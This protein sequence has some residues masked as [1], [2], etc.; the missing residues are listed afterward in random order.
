M[1]LFDDIKCKYPLPVAGA[2]KLD[3]QTK[4]TPSQFMDQYEIREDG[5]LWYEEYDIED[6]SEYSKWKKEHP[7]EPEPDE[8]KQPFGWKFFGCLGKANKR[9]VQ[10]KMSGEICFYTSLGKDHSG[11]LEFSAYFKNGQLQQLNLIK[12]EPPKSQ[13]VPNL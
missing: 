2:N 6:Y 10:E 11:W 13:D 12:N 9:W 8:T 1:G 7:N 5:T 3:Y 4:D